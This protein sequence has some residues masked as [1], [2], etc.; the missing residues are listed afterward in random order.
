MSERDMRDL[1]DAIDC[2]R[3]Q[4]NMA[5]TMLAEIKAVLGE[6]CEVRG[7]RIDELEEGLERVKMRVWWFAGASSAVAFLFSKLWPSGLG[8]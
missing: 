3:A 6:R 2:L 4:Q 5:N 1:W 7:K 8:K